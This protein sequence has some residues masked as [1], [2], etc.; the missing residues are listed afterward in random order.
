[1]GQTITVYDTNL[2][3][4]CIVLY[5]GSK[6]T[7]LRVCNHDLPIVVPIDKDL[8]WHEYQKIYTKDR[9]ECK[10]KAK[11]LDDLMALPIEVAGITY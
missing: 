4:H 3:A 8:V 11:Q 5:I 9:N 2:W 7:V 6:E 10:E 1:M